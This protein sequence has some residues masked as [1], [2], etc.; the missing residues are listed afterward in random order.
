MKLR[1][2]GLT[3]L[4]VLAAGALLF[5]LMTVLLARQF[6]SALHSVTTSYA[7]LVLPL[8]QID[9]NANKLRFHLL[10]FYMH[11]PALAVAGLHRHPAASHLDAVRAGLAAND[12]LWLAVEQSARGMRLDQADLAPLHTAYRAFERDGVAA[13]LSAAQAR[14]WTGI[15]R[16]ITATLTGYAD[17]EQ[18]LQQRIVALSAAEQQ[19]SHAILARRQRLFGGLFALVLLGL[20]LAARLAWRAIERHDAALNDSN[21]ELALANSGL[22][23]KVAFRTRALR[24]ANRE[25]SQTLRRLGAARAQ[26]VQNEKQ[27]ALGN[28][29]A[30]VAHE[31]NTPIGNALLTVSTLSHLTAQL[32]AQVA[33]GITRAQLQA[34]LRQAGESCILMERALNRASGLLDSFKQVAADR[35]GA[36]RRRFALAG[37]VAEVV[38]ARRAELQRAGC[39]VRVTVPR[40]L[41]MDSYPDSVAQVLHQLIDNSL[42]HGLAGRAAGVLTIAAGDL[43]AHWLSLS[44]GDDGVGIE[45]QWRHRVFDPFFTTRMGQGSG[46][47]GLA[48]AHN[49][50]TAILGGRIA[51]GAGATR[52]TLVDITLR[53]VAPQQP[54]ARPLPQVPAER[55]AA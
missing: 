38:A 12:A 26:L 5:A 2:L 49:I 17:F 18:L 44:I 6:D 29:V 41:S 15:V 39:D 50:V 14:D 30:G 43:D 4:T 16:P 24:H 51:L 19:R 48:I 42:L 52:G 20:V 28:L 34:H 7:A 27:A 55:E 47:L 8:R 31:L 35:G 54:A 10:A 33:I 1:T 45:P 11:N 53:K 23:Q 13:G 21:R 37:V 40:G 3:M 9:V 36:S 25:M 22:E 46:G 32:R